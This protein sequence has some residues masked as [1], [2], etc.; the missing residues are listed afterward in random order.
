MLALK[1]LGTRP[2]RPSGKTP[3][4]PPLTNITLELV[5]Y[6]TVPP[7]LWGNNVKS[8]QSKFSFTTTASHERPVC[9]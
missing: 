1:Q 9:R 6:L 4:C 2:K 7:A 8:S 3:L 5:T